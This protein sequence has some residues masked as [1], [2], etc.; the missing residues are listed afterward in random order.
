MKALGKHHHTHRADGWKLASITVNLPFLRSTALTMRK[1]GPATAY[2]DAIADRLKHLARKP[3][4]FLVLEDSAD[5]TLH[6]HLCMIYHSDDKKAIQQALKLDA[7][8]NN[9]SVM[10]KHEYRQYEPDRDQG[11]I[12]REMDAARE[13]AR[14]AGV[15]DDEEEPEDSYSLY[16]LYDQRLD[17][18]YRMKPVDIG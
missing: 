7:A 12:D 11:D 14:A 17:R 4:F 5:E 13:V 9:A 18:Y 3:R 10:F 2:G 8:S 6:A 15:P 1:K 16:Q